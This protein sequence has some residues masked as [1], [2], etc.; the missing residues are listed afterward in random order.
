M[1][2]I[3]LIILSI[4]TLFLQT[5]FIIVGIV[6]YKNDPVLYSFLGIINVVCFLFNLNS[7]KII[8]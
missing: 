2:K 4:F 3:F 8:L 5:V 7:L 1:K 6:Q